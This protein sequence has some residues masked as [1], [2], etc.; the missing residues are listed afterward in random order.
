M[1]FLNSTAVEHGAELIWAQGAYSIGHKD[2]GTQ[3]QQIDLQEQHTNVLGVFFFGLSSS[4]PV[5]VV[6]EIDSLCQLSG[7]PSRIHSA[8]KQFTI[9]HTL[10]LKLTAYYLMLAAEI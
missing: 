9:N 4:P 2:T 8:F 6:L 10:T 1:Y 5:L 3:G 7:G